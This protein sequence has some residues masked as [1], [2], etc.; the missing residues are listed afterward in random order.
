MKITDLRCAVIGKHPI[1]RIV[2][3]EG[4]HGLGEV[5]Y[6]KTYLKPWVLHF[7]DALIAYRSKLRPNPVM[8]TV[9]SRLT[10]ADIEALAAYFESIAD[11]ADSTK[12]F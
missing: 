12:G 2:T 10:D 11:C 3:D 8:Q 6:T 4:I 5:E 1:V 7:R 9:A